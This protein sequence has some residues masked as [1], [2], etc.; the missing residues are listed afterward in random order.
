MMGYKT[1]EEVIAGWREDPSKQTLIHQLYYDVDVWQASFRFYHSDEFRSVLELAHKLGKTNGHVLDIGGG[2]GVATL[3]WHH[4]GYQATLLEPD[5]SKIVG[6]GALYEVLA[7]HPVESISVYEGIAE[8][9]QFKDHSFDIVYCRQVLHHISDLPNLMREIRRI[10]K[11]DGI[12]IATREH[13]ISS[14]DDLQAFWD[15]HDLHQHTGGEYAYLE[16]EYRMA[17]GGEFQNISILRYYDSV[18]NFYPMPIEDLTQ[19]IRK[20]LCKFGLIYHLRLCVFLSKFSWIRKRMIARLN[21]KNHHPG[22][23]YSFIAY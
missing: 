22:R 2:N 13:V 10:L 8:D 9:T 18:I 4:A 19:M 6:Y 15:Q 7:D 3:A 21:E 1:V 11:K 12:L 17:I 16:S 14:P 5:P 23:M 20:E